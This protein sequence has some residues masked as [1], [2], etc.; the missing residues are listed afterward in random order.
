MSIPVG[1]FREVLSYLENELSGSQ[2]RLC[3]TPAQEQAYYTLKSILKTNSEHNPNT[4]ERK[5]IAA[6][7]RVDDVLAFADCYYFVTVISAVDRDG[8]IEM[9]LKC[10]A[11]GSLAT[12]RFR[13]D[14]LVTVSFNGHSDGRR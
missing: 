3:R 13:H 2:G 6:V 14:E 10:T 5:M 8:C 4:F 9:G 1:A 7:V 11:N 12:A